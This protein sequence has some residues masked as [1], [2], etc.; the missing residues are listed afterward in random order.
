MNLTAASVP[1]WRKRAALR[2]AGVVFGA[3]SV[4]A[5]C[6]GAAQAAT[7]LRIASAQQS[8]ASI[9]IVVAIQQK[10]FE[11]EDIAAEIID[12]DGG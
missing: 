12:F 7:T 9:P 3:W 6:A 5:L 11:A 10:L 4:V 2:F 8:I 1:R